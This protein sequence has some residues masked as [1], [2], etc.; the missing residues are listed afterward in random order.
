MLIQLVIHV[1]H[2]SAVLSILY[3]RNTSGKIELPTYL[4]TLFS[5][6]QACCL[7]NQISRDA[8]TIKTCIIQLIGEDTTIADFFKGC[9]G[10]DEQFALLKKRYFKAV[11]VSSTRHITARKF[12]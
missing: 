1:F 6:V 11:L 3:I 12:F 5:L 9:D 8:M 10:L 2:E 4:N 7:P